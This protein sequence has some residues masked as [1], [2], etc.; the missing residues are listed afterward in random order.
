MTDPRTIGD[1][2]AA[3]TAFASVVSWLP[4]IAA[5]VSIL[6]YVCRFAVWIGKRW[7]FLE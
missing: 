6:W 4:E 5:G 1:M 2:A 7:K 3:G